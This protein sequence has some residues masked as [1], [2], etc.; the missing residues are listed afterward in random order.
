MFYS[1]FYM[2]LFVGL[3]LEAY[4][5]KLEYKYFIIALHQNDR[6]V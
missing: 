5:I 1:E 6:I 3:Y 4:F 2:K